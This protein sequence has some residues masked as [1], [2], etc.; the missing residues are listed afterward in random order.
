M[1]K[2]NKTQ[3]AAIK[4]FAKKGIAATSVKDI[5]EGAG[6]SIG[7]MYGQYNK[8]EELFNELVTYATEGLNR[9]VKRFQSD[10]SP[11]DL[12]QQS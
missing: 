2:R 10:D 9:I 5:A 4:L 6:I 3:S 12:I 1:A 11:A 8:K 7:L